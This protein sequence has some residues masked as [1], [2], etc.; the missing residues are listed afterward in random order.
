M[1]CNTCHKNIC[2]CEEYVYCPGVKGDR[3]DRGDI[4]AS[5]AD[6]EDGIQDV[7]YLHEGEE[8]L[9]PESLVYNSILS[10]TITSP[11][12]YLFL[13]EADISSF[14]QNT[15]NYRLSV[16]G[17]YSPSSLRIHVVSD[18]VSPEVS[19]IQKIMINHGVLSLSAGDVIDIELENTYSF[20]LYSRSLS[21]IKCNNLTIL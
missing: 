2:S 14:F 18:T 13:F 11:G 9:I 3:G 10:Y 5:G 12:D 21:A 16:N 1:S 6:G 15:I 7:Y 8:V 20:Y 19:K 4:G 17:T